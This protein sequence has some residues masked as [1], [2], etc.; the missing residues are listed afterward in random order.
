MKLLHILFSIIGLGLLASCKKAGY[1]TKNGT[2]YYKDYLMREADHASFEELN[3]VFAKDKK[4][5][6]YR[7]I[8]ITGT[9]GANFKALDEHY[10]TTQTSVFYC[11]N[12]LAFDLFNTRRKNKIDQVA[13]ADAGSFEALKDEYAKD[14]SRAYFKG[15][16]FAVTD[17]ASF[18]PLDHMFARDTKSAYFFLKPIPGSEGRS[19]S[20]L[21]SHFAK[22]SRHVY[23][24]WTISDG[25]ST[26]G[27]RV[28]E[29]ADPTSF[30]PVS[31]FYYAI[32]KAHAYYEDKPLEA[33]DPATFSQWDAYQTDYGRDSTHVYFEDKLIREAHK[34]TFRLLTDRYTQDSLSIFYEDKP[35]KPVDLPSFA[36]LESGY[37]KDAKR[38]YYNG[39][40][41]SGAEPTSF[42]LVGN[43]AERDAAD[44]FNSYYQGKRVKL[45]Q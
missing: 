29:G 33:A 23:C 31:D 7:G 41:L 28:I 42:A 26:P 19:F 6:Y 14:K 39:R 22:D 4:Q 13:H 11:D 45:D 2:V 36:V 17:V 27:I 35:L 24:A 32:D 12:Y 18:E 38:V 3:D 37:A 30:T 8:P 25:S 15:E 9:D 34:A 16:G 43:S 1:N 10:A 44:K 21:S 40:V 20:V 5:G